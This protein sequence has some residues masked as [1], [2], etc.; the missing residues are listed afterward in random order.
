MLDTEQ[1]VVE[2]FKVG[3]FTNKQLFYYALETSVFKIF[4]KPQK[5]G[6]LESSFFCRL[7]DLLPPP[8]VHL[9]IFL[10]FS[11]QQFYRKLFNNC[12]SSYSSFIT[13]RQR[14][15]TNFVTFIE[16]CEKLLVKHRL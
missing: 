3:R 5:T 4:R 14:H 10:K 7:R 11:K 16:H 13:G 6:V 15:I 9:K 12:A 1:E 8:L 2:S